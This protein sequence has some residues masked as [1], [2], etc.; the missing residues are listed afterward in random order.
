MI[1]TI[2]SALVLLL[3]FGTLPAK[4]ENLEKK[5]SLI[6]GEKA[7]VHFIDVGQGDSI[8]IDYKDYDILIDAGGNDKGPIVVEYLKSLGVD[9]IEIMVA[10][11]PHEDHIGGLDDVLEAFEVKTIIDGGLKHT[12]STYK[13]YWNAVVAENAKYKESEGLSFCLGDGVVFRVLEMEKN[14]EEM[15]NNSIVCM[16]DHGDIEF[17][18]MGDIEFEA[19]EANLEKFE[20]IDVLKV[21]HH[22]SKTSTSLEFLEKTTPKVAVITSGEDNAYGHPHKETINRL[23]DNDIKVYNTKDFGHIVI[24]SNGKNYNIQ[25]PIKKILPKIFNTTDSSAKSFFKFRNMFN[26]IKN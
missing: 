16:L 13:D 8:F 18:F 4:A 17:L 22:G 7:V 20:D 15:N 11:H 6:G 5:Q 12:T 24:G 14:F 23:L 25:V 19:E 2:S 1:K 26:F 3:L 9:D 21:G 10:T